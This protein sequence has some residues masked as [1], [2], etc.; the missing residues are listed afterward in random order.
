MT[1]FGI[2][3]L[4]ALVFTLSL[5]GCGSGKGS[6]SDLSIARMRAI[7]SARLRRSILAVASLALNTAP[8]SGGSRSARLK[9]KSPLRLS[10]AVTEGVSDEAGLY[11]VVNHLT[12]Q[13][14]RMDLYLDAAHAVNAGTFTW[15][16]PTWKDGSPNSFPAVV[17][18]SYQITGGVRSGTNGTVDFTVTDASGLNGSMHITL[19]NAQGENGDA[20]F[21]VEGGMIRG[22]QHGHMHGDSAKWSW[23][24]TDVWLD[25]GGLLSTVT[26]E[27]GSTEKV[28]MS[29]DGSSTESYYDLYGTLWLS[30]DLDWDG[31]DILDYTDG[32]REEVDVDTGEPPSD[33]TGSSS[34]DRSKRFKRPFAAR[35]SAQKGII[36]R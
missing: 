25:A 3:A 31:V 35:S 36:H 24:E 13:S 30:G 33:E 27:D 12:D 28:E 2:F 20:D 8:E 7:S 6:G 18:S 16:I 14:G 1:R 19:V 34:E 15:P 26:F 9:R 22:T 10:R 5:I 32:S 29:P 21:T 11:Y 23:S 4:L 17:S